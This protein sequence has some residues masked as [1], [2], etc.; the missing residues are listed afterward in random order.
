MK[1]LLVMVVLLANKSWAIEREGRTRRYWMK[2]HPNGK[3]DQ[4]GHNK[5]SQDDFENYVNSYKKQ[6]REN[7]QDDEYYTDDDNDERLDVDVK[8][9]Q[10]LLNQYPEIFRINLVK[11]YQKNVRPTTTRVPVHVTRKVRMTNTIL[12]LVRL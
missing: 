12:R 6:T 7:S 8:N 10:F 5:K 4:Y 1:F 9:D 11:S 3:Y 2:P